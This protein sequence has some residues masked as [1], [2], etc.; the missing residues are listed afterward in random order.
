MTQPATNRQI[1]QDSILDTFSRQSY[2][3]NQFIYAASVSAPGSETPLFLLS[4]PVVVGAAFP[5]TYKSLFVNLRKVVCSVTGASSVLK[6]YFNPT[7]TGNGTPVTIL[8][9][10]PA[11]L[12]TPIGVLTSSPTTSANGSLVDSL[13]SAAFSTD[14]SD[15]MLIL[16]PGQKLLVTVQASAGSTTT[17][18]KLGWFE[19]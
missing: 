8:N 16:D 2:L 3:G 10:R 9:A 15:F 5:A 18:T 14:E 12:N 6:F 4:N 17:L 13:A 19:L 11:N 7:L 1:P